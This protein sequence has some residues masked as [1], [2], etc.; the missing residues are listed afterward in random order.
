MLALLAIYQD[1]ED[2]V[3]I[4]AYVP[5]VNPEFDLAV[6]VRPK[7]IQFL[8]QEPKSPSNLE[9]SKKHL[10]ELFAMVER[11]EATL[12][13]GGDKCRHRQPAACVSEI[14][15]GQI[16]VQTRRRSAAAKACRAGKDARPATA[17][18]HQ[19]DCEAELGG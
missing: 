11:T 17:L 5:G 2:L 13:A 16:H 15:D 19:A 4:G 8:Q 3:N 18:K 10:T 12:K 6:Q 7:I 1:I 9:N 14:C